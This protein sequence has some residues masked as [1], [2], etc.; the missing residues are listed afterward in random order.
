MKNKTNSL[1]HPDHLYSDNE[2]FAS[3]EASLKEK[4]KNIE[5][6]TV[7]SLTGDL[8]FKKSLFEDSVG[9]VS[10]SP[11]FGGDAVL[12]TK[13]T[14][15]NY[16]LYLNEKD[17]P[18]IITEIIGYK[19]G[20]GNDP[21]NLN[22]VEE[23]VRDLI[24]KT[25]IANENYTPI[26]I[27]L[28]HQPMHWTVKTRTH[29]ISGKVKEDKY[30]PSSTGSS[31]QRDGSS[32]GSFAAE[33]M[34]ES[35]CGRLPGFDKHIE[36]YRQPG[37]L[38]L[39]QKHMDSIN[40]SSLS[41]IFGSQESSTGK[42]QDL[43]MDKDDRA[44][45]AIS[46]IVSLSQS[47][48]V[49]NRYDDFVRSLSSQEQFQN[50]LAEIV[51][52]ADDIIHKVP[53][54]NTKS[55]VTLDR[56]FFNIDGSP[57]IDPEDGNRLKNVYEL[58]IRSCQ[59]ESKKTGVDVNNK[60]II[61]KKFG[62]NKEDLDKLNKELHKL[63]VKQFFDQNDLAKI[64]KLVNTPGVN[65]YYFPSF[66][67]PGSA[68]DSLAM[69]INSSSE[70]ALTELVKKN[71]ISQQ[72]KDKFCSKITEFKEYVLEQYNIGSDNNA[73]PRLASS[74]INGEKS[75][76]LLVRTVL[77]C[78]MIKQ[79]PRILSMNN[80]YLP[81]VEKT[82]KNIID[83]N[84]Q[85]F[86]VLL[87]SSEE[88]SLEEKERFRK[89]LNSAGITLN[90]HAK[91]SNSENVNKFE[92][93]PLVDLE[94]YKGGT[95]G[96]LLE[97]LEENIRVYGAEPES[98]NKKTGKS[99]FHGLNSLNE[100]YILLN[101]RIEYIKENEPEENQF[102]LI[103]NVYDQVDDFAKEK[104]RPITI[105]DWLKKYQSGK[106]DL[107]RLKLLMT[108]GWSHR[109]NIQDENGNTAMHL[110]TQYAAENGDL[111][112]FKILFNQQANNQTENH[113]NWGIRNNDGVSAADLVREFSE[114]LKTFVE[115]EEFREIGVSSMRDPVVKQKKNFYLML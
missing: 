34:V 112:P 78:P 67:S 76:G 90:Q 5:F 73:L 36:S 80:L 84:Q 38:G 2:I 55:G 91:K 37:A 72:E 42:I 47:E 95:G 56:Y 31:H 69:K 17:D 10:R 1:T 87:D 86:G 97:G 70:G 65:P 64:I 99:F 60:K 68:A 85:M 11:Q 105:G 71:L 21:E 96:E 102:K 28:Y 52:Y 66:D 98:I 30:D 13:D 63:A 54:P 51:N 22:H 23:A 59:L 19:A 14:E 4:H 44:M 7:D 25:G 33:N 92:T 79:N 35:A 12:L 103:K 93:L 100:V 40:K 94:D 48:F 49:G 109:Q 6:C 110:I 83:E 32:C 111:E 77:N 108:D 74:V 61:E 62:Q 27:S 43:G 3:F 106:T 81:P 58:I 104:G 107:N 88:I 75:L 39:R 57:V 45:K 18:I 113:R 101:A 89:T 8:V 115:I 82:F 16:S 15:G 53:T 26:S 114:A 41:L 20:E 24:E 50:F 29:P 46:Q 9:R